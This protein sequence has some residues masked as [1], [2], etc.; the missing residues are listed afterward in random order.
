MMSTKNVLQKGL[1]LSRT[2][3]VTF[4][5]VNNIDLEIQELWEKFG[6]WFQ[7]ERERCHKTQEDISRETGLHIKTV[8]R[9]ENGEPT[10]RSTVIKLALSINADEKLALNKAGFDVPSNENNGWYKGLDKLSPEDQKRAKRQIR[11][12]IDSYI[13]DEEKDEDFDYI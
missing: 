6:Q 11:A 4:F 1:V 7:S 2:N 12:I 5:N 9:I 3:L 8:S 10:K 13:D